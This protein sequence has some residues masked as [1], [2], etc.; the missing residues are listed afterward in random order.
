[1][2]VAEDAADGPLGAGSHQLVDAVTEVTG[3]RDA[4]VARAAA[5]SAPP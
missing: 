1:M 5:A 2:A 4:A 3:R